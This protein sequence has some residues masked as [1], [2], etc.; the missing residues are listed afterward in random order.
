MGTAS[1]G[2]LLPYRNL[3]GCSS[4]VDNLVLAT[5]VVTEG[6]STCSKENLWRMAKLPP[7]LATFLEWQL[8]ANNYQTNK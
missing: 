1:R 3:H 6:G 8:D 4:A 7:V 5:C 2:V